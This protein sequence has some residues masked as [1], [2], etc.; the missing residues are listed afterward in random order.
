MDKLF[1]LISIEKDQLRLHLRDFIIES[2]RISGITQKIC[3]DDADAYED[4][5]RLNKLTIESL[6]ELLQFI[7]P[8]GRLRSRTGMDVKR[9][10]HTPPLG[11][12]DV[13][14]ELTELLR[15]INESAYKGYGTKV[16]FA[17][18]LMFE[19][20]HP[21]TE[22]NSR[23]GRAIWLWLMWHDMDA[24]QRGFLHSFYFQT[25]QAHKSG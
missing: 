20:L 23:I 22:G 7:C 3:K 14:K 5:L 8:Q 18:H 13:V 15:L 24:M 4:L 2:N 10:N 1:E 6:L 9:G 21:F 19:R 11:G 12:Y 17:T 25:L 16:A